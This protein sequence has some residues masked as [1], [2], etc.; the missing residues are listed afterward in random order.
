MENPNPPNPAKLS[1]EAGNTPNSAGATQD[2]TSSPL[3]NVPTVSLF[4]VRVSKLDMEATVQVL[5]EAVRSGKPHQVIT[6]NPI[7][8]MT[9]LGDPGYMAIMRQAE[10]VVPDGTG[11]VWAA[12][13]IGEPVAE[14]VP[15]I[16]LMHRLF[17]VGEQYGWRAFLL[18]AD[19]DTI[20]EA[21]ERL[22]VQYPRMHFVGYHHGYF[23]AGE[24]EAIISKIRATKPDLLFVGRSV[25]TQEPWIGQYKE[26]LGIPVMMGVGGS[27]DVI[28]G[29]MK[30]APV[31]FQKMRL[32]WFH[33]LLQDPKRW[34]RMLAL[35]KFVLFVM[36]N[37]SRV[38]RDDW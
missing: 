15:G 21:Y 34:R 22:R 28:T 32:E 13:Y 18:G 19:P 20:G 38:Q 4:G 7:M 10:L 36:R 8:L 6:A 9:A 16:E 3:L 17:E 33:R 24:D 12:Q 1:Q 26:K 5:T 11:A 35:P 27:F 37:R 2:S 29:R 25:Y 30:R 23:D 31:L 14:R